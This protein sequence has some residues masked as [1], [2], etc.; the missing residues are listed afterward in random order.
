MAQSND[1]YVAKAKEIVLEKFPE[2]EGVKP[3]VSVKR[4]Q[5][6]ELSARES[7]FGPS[8]GA[9]R[10]S[11]GCARYVVTFERDIRLPGGAQMKR[12]VHVTMDESG[13]VLR[14]TSSK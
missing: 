2:M 9:G 7:S 10:G 6:K 8:V 11:E 13:H 3:S 1:R 5:S 14:V 4:S 12:L